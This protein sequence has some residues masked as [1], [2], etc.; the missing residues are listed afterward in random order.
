MAD[1]NF[2][3]LKDENFK[4]VLK[5]VFNRKLKDEKTKGLG[6]A[7][8]TFEGQAETAIRKTKKI[9]G[10]KGGGKAVKGLGRAF[11]KGGKV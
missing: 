4:K 7:Q 5:N 8:S 2:K 3:K 10:L 11:M 6:K 1:E 9:L